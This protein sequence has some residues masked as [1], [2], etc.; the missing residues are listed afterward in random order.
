MADSHSH[1][2]YRVHA[3]TMYMTLAASRPDNTHHILGYLVLYLIIAVGFA[4]MRVSFRR[5]QGTSDVKESFCSSEM[6]S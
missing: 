5:G 6:A 2:Y 4:Y 3:C 1:C